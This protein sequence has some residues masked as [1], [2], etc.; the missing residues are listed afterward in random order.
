M[1]MA[2]L[3]LATGAAET[4]ASSPLYQVPQATSSAQIASAAEAAVNAA[5]GL[6][7]EPDASVAVTESDP[8]EVKGSLSKIY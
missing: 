3:G 4:T 1:A 5:L 8:K 7:Q 2:S 6:P